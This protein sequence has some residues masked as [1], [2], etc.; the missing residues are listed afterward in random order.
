MSRSIFALVNDQD[1]SYFGHEG[2]G[3]DS[4]GYIEQ[5]RRA[6]FGKSYAAEPEKLIAELSRDEA[7]KEA[8]T[9]LLTIPNT[10][11]VEYN[12]HI[13]STILKY[14]APELGWR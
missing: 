11:G 7:I 10:L 3:A 12:V 8:D 1:R 13:L 5:D 9:L 4:F 6:V 2:K 14:I